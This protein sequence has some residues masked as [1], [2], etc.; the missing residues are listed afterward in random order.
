MLS[1]V[2]R[3][4]FCQMIILSV[5]GFGWKDG[6]GL[7]IYACA[8]IDK[9]N[10]QAAEEEAGRLRANGCNL[11]GGYG[12][13]AEGGPGYR[14]REHNR[15][16]N[17]LELHAVCGPD[18]KNCNPECATPSESCHHSARPHRCEVLLRCKYPGQKAVAQGNTCTCEW[19]DSCSADDD[20]TSRHGAMV[21]NER[22][23]CGCS[24]PATCPTCS[25]PALKKSRTKPLK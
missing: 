20:C 6:H 25:A 7:P 11:S 21:H 22:G 17:Y 2:G 15:C 23:E 5:A 8:T 16:V 19:P 18:F 3:F 9:N 14:S 10:A 4:L 24:V 13:G 1:V 12:C